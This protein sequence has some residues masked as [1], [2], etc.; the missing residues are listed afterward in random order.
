MQQSNNI[1][2]TVAKAVKY[3]KSPAFGGNMDFY[4]VAG[5]CQGGPLDLSTFETDADYSVDFNGRSKV[6]AKGAVVYRG[7]YA[8]ETSNPGWELRAGVKPP[9]LP[10]PKRAATVVWLSPTS[11]EAG[12]KVQIA[13]SGADFTQQAAVG[14]S[15][16]GV[17]VSN[18]TV[19]SASRI[20]AILRIAGGAAPTVRSL[21]VSA[22]SGISNPTSFRIRARRP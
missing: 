21:T 1:V 12:S 3:V 14:V 20:T 13:L 11:G 7:A 4:P 22:P 10:S 9:A 16:S 6:E 8:G 2:D 18:V 15:G 5:Q 19:E 17:E